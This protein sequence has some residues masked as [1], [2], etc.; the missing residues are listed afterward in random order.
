M[1]ISSVT[2]M[3][4]RTV[5]ACRQMK[6]D[7]QCVFVSQDYLPIS[8]FKSTLHCLLRKHFFHVAKVQIFLALKIGVRWPILYRQIAMR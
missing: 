8:A 1:K 4:M 7:W 2:L 6:W 5:S 3:P